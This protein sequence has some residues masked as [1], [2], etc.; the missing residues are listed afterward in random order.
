[1]A[2]ASPESGA[3]VST[4]VAG[5]DRVLDDLRIGDNVVWRVRDLDDYQ[6]FVTPF[7]KASVAAGRQ[8]IYL[9]FGQHPPLL[10]AGPGIRVVNVDARDG[11]E[12]FTAT[13]WHQVDTWG[14]GAFYVCDCLSDLLQV[15]AT[16]TMVGYFFR[17]ICPFLYELETVAWFALDPRRHSRNTLERIR[18]TTQ[19]MIDVHRADRDMQIQPV[20]VWRRQS[21]TM[22]LPHHYRNGEFQPVT[23]SSDATRLQAAIE[24][25]DLTAA[26]LPDSHDQLFSD[27]ANRL[28]EGG[29]EQQES[30][31]QRI[32]RTLISREPR[33][34]SLAGQYLS[35]EQLLAIHGRTIGSGFIGGKA[36]GMLLARAILVNSEPT[37]DVAWSQAMEPHDSLFMASD[38]WYAFLV[39][40][41]LWP[42]FMTQ[43]SREGFFRDAPTLQASILAG[44]FPAEVRPE[45]MRLL[46]HFGQYPILVRSSSLLEDG[47]GNAFAGKY[48]SVFLNNQG[49]PEL[50]LQALEQAIR[51]VYAS[52]FSHDA[53]HYRKAR[54]LDQAEE[55]MALLIQRV[56]G[57]FHGAWY[58][59]D[60]A[61]VGVSRNAF[62]WDSSMDPKAGMVRLVVG[63]GTRAVDRISGDHA[64]VVALDQPLR[65]PF[66]SR[67]ESYSHSQ[68]MI[69]LLDVAADGLTALPLSR[70]TAEAPHLPLQHLGEPDRQ[71]SERARE[72]GLPGNV[73][74]LTFDPLIRR[75]RFVERMT[76]LLSCLEQAYQHPVDVEFTLHLD[77]NGEPSFNLVQCRPLATLGEQPAQPMPQRPE[78]NALLLASD[79]HFMGG[80]INLPIDRVVLIQATEYSVLPLA[81]KYAVASRIG[82]L[83]RT[84]PEHDRVLL[85]GPGRWGTSSPELGVPAGF[86]DLSRASV[87]VEIA[88]MGNGMMPDLSYGSHF[89][90]DLVESGIAYVALFPDDR[91]SFWSP[92]WLSRHGE[93]EHQ[94]GCLQ[95]WALAE[96]SLR[97]RADITEQRLLAGNGDQLS[98][99]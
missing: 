98:G 18:T 27:A 22:F 95:L 5:L 34:L 73:W 40:N 69:D 81:D 24:Q 35:L 38:T 42:L 36:V 23:D 17:V 62:V 64:W 92:D 26:P 33:M 16:D 70:L 48:D 63:L 4:G 32:L 29:A 61:G 87:L 13:V 28:Q 9:R 56:N 57:R 12:S 75:S 68:H 67:D 50:R 52:A 11:F 44:S 21:P 43:R 58:L 46:D 91:G 15:W 86:A 10:S 51:E 45:L 80:N 41:G 7:V 88:D 20:K 79:G 65:H 89:F 82:E 30:L 37:E 99:G 78:D 74:R 2:T 39:H 31:R 1:M 6:R 66:R 54:G 14:R 90:Q 49:D 96:G 8:I 85:A 59:P 19:V 71:A 77:T 53:L 83:L 84:L 94:E 93:L 72:L 3:R 97:V 47:F 25:Q 55:P 76:R 60:A